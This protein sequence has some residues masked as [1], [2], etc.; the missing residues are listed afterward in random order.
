MRRMTLWCVLLLVVCA[1]GASA[2]LGSGTGGSGYDPGN[3]MVIYEPQYVG[4]EALATF[5]GGTSIRVTTFLYGSGSG[6]WQGGN[7][8]GPSYGGAFGNGYGG[9]RGGYGGNDYGNGGYYGGRSGGY[10]G[11][12]G[13][14]WDGGGRRGR[15][16]RW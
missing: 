16:G 12:Y 3:I 10:D 6:G 13:G 9:G 14:G 15:G 4:A 11:G 8:G 2:Q 7:G 5:L 1:T